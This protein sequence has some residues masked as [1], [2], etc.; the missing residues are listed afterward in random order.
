MY[1]SLYLQLKAIHIL[2][3]D[4]R[5]KLA[6]QFLDAMARKNGLNAFSMRTNHVATLASSWLY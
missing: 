3:V 4:I 1:N 2:Q 6:I 5:S